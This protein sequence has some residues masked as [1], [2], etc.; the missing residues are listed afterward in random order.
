MSKTSPSAEISP[1]SE[2]YNSNMLAIHKTRA[3]LGEIWI[4][5]EIDN[6]VI[7][8]SCMRLL[9]MAQSGKFERIVIYI[10]SP[11]GSVSDGFALIDFIQN[12]PVPVWTVNIGA[13][14]SMGLGIFLAGERRF[15]MPRST[16]LM[17]TASYSI[18]GEKT[19][20]H[21]AMA[22]FISGEMKSM[23][24]YFASKTNRSAKWW[25][26]KMKKADYWFRAEEAV[27]LGV[28]TEILTPETFKDLLSNPFAEGA[29]EKVVLEG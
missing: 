19:Y 27:S 20:E 2:R 11:G 7:E 16:F 1:G 29:E 9:S 22:K 10:N 8:M 25:L 14:Y 15:A 24:E 23:G 3:K 17:H 12:I 6:D 26:D 18:E 21:E 13:A 28:A 4:N 5:S